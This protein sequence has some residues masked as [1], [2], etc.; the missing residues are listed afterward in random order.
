MQS[1][2]LVTPLTGPPIDLKLGMTAA[3]T[4]TRPTLTQI[5]ATECHTIYSPVAVCTKWPCC[6]TAVYIYRV[7][8]NCSY[9]HLRGS[10]A[11]AGVWRVYTELSTRLWQ[12]ELAGHRIYWF[13]WN[14]SHFTVHTYIVFFF[15]CSFV[16]LKVEKLDKVEY[17]HI[18]PKYRYM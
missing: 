6:C 7:T 17:C 11:A 13:V 5:T 16:P 10:R 4:G 9:R 15:Y 18:L 8:P 3:G 2:S 14:V 12:L 1:P